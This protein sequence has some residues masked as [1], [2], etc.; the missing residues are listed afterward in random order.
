M[1]YSIVE[2]FKT[3][4]GEGQLAGT[5]A[6]FVRFAG[7]NLW[8]GKSDDRARDAE[9]N[10][11]C[12]PM[13]CDTDFLPR[14]KGLDALEVARYINDA[15]PAPLV[16]FTG[17]EPLLQLTAQLLIQVQMIDFVRTIAVE[18][19]GTVELDETVAR[20]IDHVCVSPKVAV[21]KLKLIRGTEL[22]V[23]FPAYNP[24][25]YG[26][27]GHNFDH[28]YVSPE[29]TTSREHVGVSVVERANEQ[30]AAEFCLDH[31]EWRL[32]LQS[33]KHLGLP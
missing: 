5:P 2:V 28:L 15:G 21:E 29:A 25:A 32:S 18:T 9:R 14:E 13:F 7:C 27:I 16:V 33:H 8:S 10:V 24:L 6:I 23:V 11:A 3:L 22:K 12:C 20:H 31:P 4:Q 1:T 30:R 17:G 19:N 26:E